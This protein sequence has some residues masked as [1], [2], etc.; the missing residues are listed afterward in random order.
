MG[1]VEWTPFSEFLLFV[2]AAILFIAVGLFT[3]MLIRPNRPNPQKLETYESG[4][5]L[6]SRTWG[7]VNI[8]F[9]LLAIIFLLFEVEIVFLFPWAVVFGDKQLIAET[10][11]LWGWFTF[12]EMLI[13]VSILFL[14]LIYA[15]RKGYLDW[16]K[17]V[18]KESGFKS[19]VPTELYDKIN[20]KYA[21]E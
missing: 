12:I 10:E 13:F 20:K 2:V 15:W 18:Q 9:Y 1:D 11:G 5:G 21:A 14:G 17:P 16:P 3:A 19:P 8:R 6:L 4:E 7:Q